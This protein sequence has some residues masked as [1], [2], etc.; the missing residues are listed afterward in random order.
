MNC[1]VERTSNALFHTNEGLAGEK[2]VKSSSLS[3]HNEILST[4]FCW[5]QLSCKSLLL[6]KNTTALKLFAHHFSLSRLSKKNLE[7]S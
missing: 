7:T 5:Q 2:G 6:L 1:K 4:K 3:R